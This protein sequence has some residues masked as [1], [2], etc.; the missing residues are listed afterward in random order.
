M[1]QIMAYITLP[2]SVVE[3]LWRSPYFLEY[4]VGGKIR[5]DDRVNDFQSITV[6]YLSSS[7]NLNHPP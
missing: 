3:V 4:L 5:T 2:T 7:L 6:G 1:D